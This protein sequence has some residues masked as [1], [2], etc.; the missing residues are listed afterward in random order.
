MSF[1]SDLIDNI[2]DLVERELDLYA[3]IVYGSDPPDSGICMIP[4][5]T[6]PSETY[7]DKG[8]LYRMPVVL[9]GKNANQQLL[10]NDLTAIHGL[11]TRRLD[12]SDLST[13]DC[14]MVDISTT[15]LP[16]II[17]REQNKQWICGSSLEVAFYWSK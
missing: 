5:P 7:L 4:G 17:G 3:D 16:S 1:Y 8:M 6:G 10:L 12:Y 13:E 9:N 14:Q 2:V 15:A 11:L